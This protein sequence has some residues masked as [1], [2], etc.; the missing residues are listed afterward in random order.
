MASKKSKQIDIERAALSLVSNEKVGWE[1]ATAFVTEKV[2]FNMRNLI[3]QLRRNY[4]G[5][6]EQPV[7]PQT[8]RKKI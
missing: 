3:R 7:D 2:A 1:T 6:F 4:W 8:G 5:V